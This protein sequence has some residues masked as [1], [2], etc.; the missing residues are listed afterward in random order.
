MDQVRS[1]HGS[2]Q[3]WLWIRSDLVMDQ[4]RSDHGS[5]HGVSMK[6]ATCLPLRDSNPISAFFPT[7]RVL[8]SQPQLTPLEYTRSGADVDVDVVLQANLWSRRM[9]P[10]ETSTH[11]K[12]S[13]KTNSSFILLRT[14]ISNLSAKWVSNMGVHTDQLF[15][16]CPL[17]IVVFFSTY[18]F[19]GAA[20]GRLPFRERYCRIADLPNPATERDGQREIQ[21]R[22][23]GDPETYQ[24]GSTYR[25][26]LY[27]SSPSFFRGFILLALREGREG[28]VPGDFAGNF[29]IID[30]GDTRFMNACPLAVTETMPRRRTRMQVLWTA[31]PAGSGCVV[32]RARITQKKSVHSFDEG[33]LFRKLC[34]K[35]CVCVYECCVC[36]C[37]VLCVCVYECSVYPLHTTE[38]PLQG[39]CAC[40]TAKYRLAFYG[41]WSEK[42]HP[43]DYPREWP[44]SH[45][46][47]PGPAELLSVCRLRYPCAYLQ[48]YRRAN[49]WSALIGASH[50]KSY[51][52]W[53]YGGYASE[54]VRQVAEL[55]SPVKMEEEIRQKDSVT[56]QLRVHQPLPWLNPVQ[57]TWG[58]VAP[59]LELDGGSL[60]A[61]VLQTERKLKSK[62]VTACVLLERT[63]DA[64]RGNGPE[65]R[66]RRQEQAEGS[67]TP[68]SL[69]QHPA[70]QRPVSGQQARRPPGQDKVPEG[71][72]GLQPPL[73]HRVVAEPSSTKPRHPVHRMDRT[74]DSGKWRG[75]GVCVM[76]NNSW[77]NN[78]NVV[79]L[80]CSCSP[81]MELLALKFRTFYLPREFTSVIINTVYI[82]PQANMDIA[83]C[84]LHEALTQF[85]AQHRD[86]ALIVVGD[87]NSANLKHAVP[88][89]YQHITFPTRGNRTLDHCYTPYK[90]SY[91]ALAHPPFGKS[92]HAAIFLLPKYKQRLKREAPVQG[93]VARWTDQLVAALQ[94]ALDD[95]DWDMFRRSTDDVSEFTEAVVGFIGKLVDDTIPRITIKEF[96]NQKPWVDK[97]IREALNSRTAAY[98][99]GLI[100][101]NMDEYKSAA[102][103]V[104]RAVREAKRRYGRKLETQFQQSGSRSLWQGLR[105]ITD[106]R[107]S[108]SRLMSVDE[109]LANEL[110]T[111]FTRIEAT[112]SSANA[113][114]SNANSANASS[115]NA[116][117]ASANGNGTIGAANGACAEPT[118][119]QCPLIITESDVRRVF[120]RVNTR[121][122]MGPDGICGRVFKACADQLAPVFTDIF[123]LSLMLGIVPS[124]FKRST[125]VPVP[126][127]PRPSGLND[128]R[129]VALTSVVMKC[130]EKLVRD[131]ITSSLPA[132]MDPLQFA[133]RHNRSTDDVIAHLLHTTLTHLDKGRG[134]C[135]LRYSLYT[136]DCTATSSSTIIIKFADDTIVMGMISDN[137]ERAYLEEIKDLENW[138]QGNNLL[139]NVSKTKEL[140]VDC[141]KKQEWHYYPVRISGT[142]VERVDSFRYLGV[143]ISQDL[144][145]SRHINSLAKKARQRLYHLR[146]LR[147]FRLPS[148]VLRNFYT[149]TIESILTGNITVWFG[150]STKQD[151]QAL[152][153]VV[154]SAECITHTE[155]PDLQTIYYKQCQTK[156]RRIVKDPT[157]PNNRLFSLLRAA[158]GRMSLECVRVHMCVC[159][160][161]YVHVCVYVCVRVIVHKE[162]SLHAFVRWLLCIKSSHYMPLCH[163]HVCMCVSARVIVHKE[164]SLHAFV[165]GDD[166]MTV[167]KTK[168]QWPAWQ[169]LNMRTA[170]SAEFS[171]DSTRHLMSFLTMLGPSP[172]WNVGLSGENLC[173]HECG[174]VQRLV[175]DLLPWDAGTDYGVTYESPNKPSIPQERI[176]PLTSLD[177]PQSPF[178]NPQGGPILPLA[179]VVVERMARK[180]GEEL[181]CVASLHYGFIPTPDSPD[182]VQYNCSSSTSH[183][184]RMRLL[185]WWPRPHSDAVVCFSCLQG[186]QCNAVP[187]TV[188]DIVADIAPEETEE[189]DGTPETCIYSNWSP[190]S[191]CSSSTCDTG[192][193]MRQRMLK[194][195]LDASVPCLHTQ[196]FEACMGPGCK[197]EAECERDPH[198]HS[199]GLLHIKSSHFVRG[200]LHIKSSHFVRV[201]AYK[202][203][204]FCAIGLVLLLREIQYIVSVR[205]FEQAGEC[206]VCHLTEPSPCMLSDWISWSPCSATCGMGM[207]SRER[208][209]K[210]F[211]EDG[212][213]CE[214]TTEETEKCVVNENC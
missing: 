156:A 63:K 81:N 35:V 78:A 154:R 70:S 21:L 121:K 204:S 135:P 148:K 87:F 36:V 168:A 82:P 93:E 32:L 2:G 179:R 118:I 127:K 124:S 190:W 186:E 4:V 116:N 212:S 53:Q 85:Q 189:G 209:V 167:I 33:S 183:L 213:V 185:D 169:P 126:K 62:C 194:A 51:K 40:G 128:Y 111:F 180:V 175:K 48:A 139:Q 150:N 134:L 18:A 192:R 108:P 75:G 64:T 141:S 109:S 99:T 122:A 54:G 159:V 7:F 3:I 144:S 140:I 1:D 39:C 157:H 6:A 17:L 132:S 162:Q 90:D 187:D 163:V 25:V 147:D 197:E 50:S 68:S 193:R 123:N 69:P 120:K 136:Y 88:N 201:I 117:S 42:V 155:L 67:G 86:A 52:L 119:E 26:S 46:P 96:P 104:R 178:Y 207:R 9:L 115:A 12:P 182:P 66:E 74:A 103:G 30:E 94:D 47:G 210:Q 112:S 177:H 131:F 57:L 138:C 91:K 27:T 205:P 130:F 200:L 113:S 107:S 59:R 10:D 152:Q 174:W 102:Y 106:Y 20:A 202:E 214:E 92:D 160:R 71:H 34:E 29:K 206:C 73:L 8:L 165:H 196:D 49:H 43:K 105:T 198:T 125:I 171:V 72:S 153:R 188:D 38:K 79:T 76:V 15:L 98:N 77:C 146:H 145:W 84:E 83:L 173:T 184:G 142:T 161:V 195:Q 37:C 166:V 23:E 13:S 158:A 149:C 5:D 44:P 172:D 101:G 110:N 211:P 65:G 14:K 143:H 28:D 58:R 133:Y 45:A 151:R 137:E 80:A 170:P 11:P 16:R 199:G 191:A 56:L 129:P 100:S 19:A 89:L 95:A 55:G 41:N 61:E 31:P 176:R 164:Q 24:P 208:Y 22:V 97:T 114:S 181:R 203:Q 60:V